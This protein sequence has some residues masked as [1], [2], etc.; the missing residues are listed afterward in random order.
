MA[1]KTTAARAK[2]RY[3]V[4]PSVR[5]VEH[6]VASL[7][8]K[9]GRTLDEW[10]ALVKAKG[11]KDEAARRDWL[12]AEHGL[13]TNAAWWIAGRADGKGWE[14]G[15]PHRYL[16]A[17]AGYVESMYEG[18]KAGLRPIHDRLLALGRGLGKD[19]K[20][21]PCQTIVPLYRNH[22]FAQVK[23]STRTRIDL[24]LALGRTKTPKR[25]LLTGGLEK[26]DRITH[27]IPIGSI[28]EVDAEVERWLRKAY[29][30]DV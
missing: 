11:P 7:K 17:A 1:T 15:D 28:E 5:L 30:L 18:G 2:P 3:D 16:V 21:C 6:W 27:R 13:G 14:D 24:G 26:K 12:K 4:H 10:I 20:V 22:V 9:T 25:L 19:V 8:E 23:P 29:D